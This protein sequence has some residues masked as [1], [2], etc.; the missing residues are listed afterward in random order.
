ME[1]LRKCETLHNRDRNVAGKISNFVGLFPVWYGVGRSKTYALARAMILI[2]DS[3]LESP[4]Q[5]KDLVGRM[6]RQI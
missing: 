6:S 3:S 4:H 2:R 1:L 5:I